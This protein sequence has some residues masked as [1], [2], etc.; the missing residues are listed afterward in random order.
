MDWF[1]FY[2]R[3][4]ETECFVHDLIVIIYAKIYIQILISLTKPIITIQA[5]YMYQKT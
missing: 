1:F 4:Y 2:H 3:N 5:N